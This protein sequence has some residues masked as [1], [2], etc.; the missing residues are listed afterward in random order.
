MRERGS[1]RTGFRAW[2]SRVRASVALV[3]KLAEEVRGKERMVRKLLSSR[4]P[5]PA[6]IG[7]LVIEIDACCKQIEE[8]RAATLGT[9]AQRDRP[10]GNLLTADP[11]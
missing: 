6:A 8:I 1:G 11:T 3:D 10:T 9:R 5:D 2:T 7:T 4:T